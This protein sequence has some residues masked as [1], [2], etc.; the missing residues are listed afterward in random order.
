MAVSNPRLTAARLGGLTGS[1]F[2]LKVPGSFGGAAFAF[3]GAAARGRV[4]LTTGADIMSIRYK[5]KEIRVTYDLGSMGRA[6]LSTVHMPCQLDPCKR[7]H[8]P[9]KSC[10][11]NK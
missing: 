10:K 7:I 3:F 8:F 11:A 4:R 9:H 2:T 1:R 5:T 6:R